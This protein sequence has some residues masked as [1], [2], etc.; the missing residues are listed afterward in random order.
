MNPPATPVAANTNTNSSPPRRRSLPGG[1][2]QASR[3]NAPSSGP[4]SLVL[5]SFNTASQT[6]QQSRRLL[7]R[8][9]GL[10]PEAQLALH[11]G[12]AVQ[13]HSIK[14]RAEGAFGFSA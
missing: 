2:R 14:T 3:S 9:G 7:G 10:L 1:P 13:V 4:S 5:E 8:A 12:W 6:L 11:H